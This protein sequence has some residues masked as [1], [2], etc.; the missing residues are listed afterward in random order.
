MDATQLWATIRSERAALASDLATLSG[1]QWERPSWCTGWTVRDVLAHMTATAR[2]TPISFFPKLAASAFSLTTLQA[3]GLAKERGATPA[4]TLERF[5]AVES[6]RRRPPGP[7]ATMLGETLV[8]AEDIRRPLGIARD[9]PVPA[10]VATAD[11]FKGSNLV[12]GTKRRI[13]GVEL[14]ATD[15]AW[16]HGEGPRATGPMASLL[17]AMTGRKGALASLEGD[18]VAILAGRP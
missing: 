11:F 18:G 1:G 16:R 10:L 3:K 15:T 6:S 4:E 7:L 14:V 12:L 17:L 5:R 2:L 13:D 9:Y 8:H